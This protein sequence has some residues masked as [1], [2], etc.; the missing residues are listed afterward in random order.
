ML[1]ARWGCPVN[2]LPAISTLTTLLRPGPCPQVAL[3][4]LWRKGSSVPRAPVSLPLPPSGE[5]SRA[6]KSEVLVTLLGQMI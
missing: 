6:P 1:L 4:I 5:K 3:V 2:N